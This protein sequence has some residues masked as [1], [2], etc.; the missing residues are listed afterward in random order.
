MADRIQL[1]DGTFF[2]LKTGETPEQA[3]AVA[4]Q[5]YPDAF[6]APVSAAPKQDTSGFKAAAA[7]GVE[8][9]G[10]EFEL[11]K[12]KLGLKSE[13]EAQR[14]FE[15]A[16]Q[17]AAQ[18]FTPTEKGWTEDPL[19]KFKETLGGSVPYMV[20]PAAAGLAALA[21][22]VT[23]PVAAGLGLL[24]A[25]AVSAGQFTG[26]NLAAQIDAGKTL[27]QASG[28]AALGAAIPQALLDTAAMALLPGVGKLFGSV[29][30]K[31]TTEQAK[32]IAS[33]TLLKTAADYT[34]KTGAAMTR[35]GFTEAAQQA[36]ERVQAGLNIADPEARAEYVESFIGGAVLA[37]AGAPIGRA[38]ER[39]GAKRQAEEAIRKEQ[40]DAAA[41]A[42]AEEEAAKTTPEA[43]RA[44]EASY[45][46]AE[47]QL[48]ALNAQV[49]AAKPAKNAPADAK[50]AYEEL[51]K[52]RAEFVNGTFKPLKQEY[53]KR[54]GAIAQMYDQQMAAAE[55]AAA[56]TQQAAV[57]PIPNAEPQRDVQ[58]LM[59]EQITLRNQL[60]AL[61]GRLAQAAPEQFDA[62]NAQRQELQRRIDARATLIEEMGGTPLRAA[63][64]EQA[65][66]AKMQAIDTRLEKLNAAYATA[67]ENRDYDK[68]ADAKDQLLI[69][70]QER[71]A[72]TAKTA[73][74]MQALQTQQ[75]AAQQRGQ[76][77]DMFPEAPAAPTTT[78]DDQIKQQ[79]LEEEKDRAL[80]GPEAKRASAEQAFSEA[81]I[82]PRGQLEPITPMPELKV[83]EAVQDKQVEAFEA[84]SDTVRAAEAAL[85]EA[86]KTKDTPTL[87]AAID[88][89]NEA[90]NAQ[91]RA[92]KTIGQRPV[93]PSEPFMLDI[94]S[95]ANIINTAIN[96]N[97]TKLIS[98][99]ARHADTTALRE[100]LDANKTERERLINVLEGRLDLG[101]TGKAK[102]TGE[103][104]RSVKR[105]RADLF[106]KQYD[107]K[108]RESFKNGTNTEVIKKPRTELVQEF[109]RDK[110]GN[111]V[112]GDDGK[113]V[114]VK[115]Y[116]RPVLDK[117]GQPV[118]D[119]VRLQDIYD[120]GGPAAVEYEN[121]MQA[122]EE[123]SK[124]VTTKQG[125]AKESLYEQMVR[126]YAELEEL[127]ARLESGIA[128]PTMREK[129]A[130]AQAAL[131][132]GEAP[133]SRQ[134]DAGERY[135][136]QR[137]ITAKQNK[138]NMLAGKIIPI[139]DQILALHN[140]LY[141][142][143]PLEKPSKVAKKKATAARKEARTQATAIQKG[144]A[145]T[146]KSRGAATASRINAGDVRKEAETSQKM[147]DL[148]QELGMREPAYEKYSKEL[149]RRLEALKK[150]HGA[151]DPAVN[152]FRSTVGDLRKDKAVE[153]GKTTPEY[154]AV[155]KEQIEYFKQTL[156]NVNYVV[157]AQR[158]PSQRTPQVTRK[159]SAA[160]KRLV[161]SSPESK[162]ESAREQEAYRKYRGSL[163]SFAE[164]I[165][166]EKEGREEDRF[167]RG[168]ETESVALAPS[169]VAKLERGDLRGALTDVSKDS[170]V[171]GFS[172]AVAERL[173]DFLDATDVRV[174]ADLRDPEGKKALGAATSKLI[175][176]SR[177][178]GLSVETLLHEGTH[179]AAE[180]IVQLAEDA[181]NKLTRE[182]KLAVNELKAL[183]ARVKTNPKITSKNAKSSLSEFV[184]E[185]MSNRNLQKQL[186][187]QKWRMSDM[188]QG[189]K[190]V[191]MRMLGLDK[192]ETMFGASVVAV[193]QLFV[194]SSVRN[195]G[196]KAEV[197]VTRNLS[198]KDI[199]ALHDG[200]NSMKQFAD[201][202]G[203]LIKQK[204]RTP[205]DVER[206]AM[207]A[208]Q[209]MGKDLD[210]TLS[211]PTADT[212]DYKAMATMSDGKLYDENNPLHY[213]EATPATFA[214]LQ[215]MEDPWL[216]KREA[217]TVAQQRKD[218]FT[219]LAQFFSDNYTNYTLAETAL[220]LKAASKYAVLS[221]KDGKLRLAELAPNNRH[222]VAVVGKE[223]ADAVIEQLRAGKNLKQAFLDGLQKNAD[224][225]AKNN[226]R[227]NGWK[228]FDQVAPSKTDDLVSRYTDEEV[229]NAL[230]ETGYDGGEFADDTE[231]V[232]QLIQD[233]L[234]EDRRKPSSGNLEA[235]AIELNAGCAGTPWC[236]GASV[237][238]A[239]SQIAE[240]DFYVYY[241]NGRPEVA[242]RM[243]GTGK[244]G[245]VR[246]N[247]PNQALDPEQQKIA[248]NFLRANKFER[249]DE[250]LSEFERRE[251]LVK[252]AK[253]EAKL[254][255]TDLLGEKSPLDSDGEVDA[256]EVSR[257]LKFRT[258]DGYG[259]RPK[260]VDS[261]VDFFGKQ[262]LDAATRAYENNE[263]VFSNIRV[264]ETT[265]RKG[266]AV[267]FAG[268]EYTATTDSL[269]AVKEITLSVYSYSR[270]PAEAVTFPNLKD[271][272]DLDIFSG[273]LV[274]PSLKTV[275]EV[276]FFRSESNGARAKIVLP[277]N[278]TVKE[279]HG[280]GDSAG[281]IEGPTTIELV[282]LAQKTGSLTLELPDTKYVA[283]AADTRGIS[284]GYARSAVEAVNDALEA[285][286]IDYTNRGQ[287]MRGE[288][289]PAQ[290]ATF[291][292]IAKPAVSKF[293]KAL[294]KEFGVETVEQT[295]SGTD[296]AEVDY[297]TA[298]REVIPDVLAANNYSREA[299]DKMAKVIKAATGADVT[300]PEGQL[301]APK[302]VGNP[303]YDQTFT[304]APEERR[305]APKDVGV[306]GDEKKGFSF[307]RKK[308]QAD[309]VVGRELGVV[310][311]LLGNILGLAGRVQFIDQYA[312]LEASIRKGLDAGVISDLEATN[313]NYLLRFGQQ[314][315]Q[316][317]GQFMTNGPVRAEI[318]KKAG[319]VET[320]YRS[321]KGTNMIDVAN[322]L[323]KAKLGDDIEQENMFTVY[324][325]GKRANDPSVG[326]DKLNFK[327][328]AKA[329]AEY[330]TV[331]SRL[332][333]SPEA[334]KAFEEAAKL[335]QEYNAGL[336]D[337]L[338]QTGALSAKKAAELKSISY[339]PFYRINGNGE[340]QLMIDKEHPVRIASIKDQ[341]QLKELI[342]GNTAILPIFTS[343]AQN[344]F[345]L[346][347][348]GLRNQAVK[349]TAFMLRKLGI[350]DRI[351][352]GMGPA[353]QNVVRFFKNGEP[354]H[355]VID[356]DAF[357]IPAELIV[358]GME[359]IKT[360]LPAV[361]K[362]LALPADILRSFV[363][364]NPAYA[365]RQM[366]RDPLNAWM[367]TGTDAVPVLSSMK[368]LAKM[369][370]GR[371]DA[372]RKLMETGAISS[373]VYSG[374]ERDMAM[375]MRDISAGKPFWAKA[376][377]KL[378]TFA[379]QGDASTRAV[380]YKDSL[381]KGMSEQEALLRTLESMN[382]SRR[383]VSPSMH[384]LS[385]MI[386]F[387]NAQIQGLDVIYR[388]FKGDMPYSK[389]LE[390]RA[391]MARRGVLI[392][393]GT[394]AYAAMMEDDEA[395]QR[396]KPEERY[397]SWFV[398]VPGF[399]EP[400]RVPIPFEM[401]FLFKA[402]PEAVWN[403]A[404][405]D[406]KA[407]K[408]LSG[409]GKLA[410]QTV[411]LSMPQAIKPLTEAVLGKSFYSGDI[412]SLREKD[413]DATQR[414]REN[415]TEVAKTIG[416]VTGKVGLSPITIDHLIRGYTAGLGIALVQLANPLLASDAKAAVE[417]PTT[418]DSKLPIIGNLFQPV[419]GRGTLDEA[420]ARM[421]EIRQAKGTYNKMVEE[422]RRAEAQ[423][424]A[425]AYAN[426]L[427]A[428]S[429]S[430]SVQKRLGDLAAV[431]RQ[432]RSS[433]TM[434]TA[435]KDAKLAQIDKMKTALAKQFL[436]A[437]D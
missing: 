46:T 354:H 83:E 295:L 84:A 419:E 380:V 224:D 391:K 71:E 10:G 349:E 232:E 178:G 101:G 85:A 20:A 67:L 322:A 321:A 213:V 407:D 41:K 294:E 3:L 91:T 215:A 262:Y 12:G 186:A 367:T 257:L 75:M 212:L 387:F 297:K 346:T 410:M 28:A 313:A 122:V 131:G 190:S 431:E 107:A 238:T 29:G 121:V 420:Y 23:A 270:K 263:F 219:S 281:V 221:G 401:G 355:V 16:Q 242:V 36:L 328:P 358:R 134:M 300:Y 13:A 193:E 405:Q 136:L 290:T 175:E 104:L 249:V 260:P 166:S 268:K 217:D 333:G 196:G 259:I 69:A 332:N 76:T 159:Q 251:A 230:G 168:V 278:A 183:Y 237:G 315:S 124:K 389:Q 258:I 49:G 291:E 363:V 100:A 255:V 86:V 382:F 369:V 95:P 160:P 408:A 74:Q 301:I 277:P 145:K 348:M 116:E 21:A 114:V 139:R 398:Y 59:D 152:F 164:G 56:P 151:N 250:Y 353:G 9:L 98:D 26:S 73:Q 120:Q 307:L 52:A 181:P 96:N 316:F 361:M 298:F 430:G 44:L 386:P 54:K 231:L 428:I 275:S 81:Q 27:E 403:V 141:V 265:A 342:G 99:L 424:Y 123:L 182:Q 233:G 22:P 138:F 188:W 88:K 72:L 282:T 113:P 220:V 37:G 331:L 338:V 169:T 119:V 204:D 296:I 184:A 279:V 274:L 397:S 14:E 422:G 379:M 347:G 198:A 214:A 345:M 172:R 394:L 320:V 78:V 70:K 103:P 319:G 225:N 143:T 93:A 390:I 77:L 324:L 208:I 24:G 167:L 15:A 370:A 436:A 203:P 429:I 1:P 350:A 254:S 201:Q 199:A 80:Y 402:L 180:R 329:K 416:A 293:F 302:R 158:A 243:D 409:I 51:K 392:A 161:T 359:G 406:E 226:E 341:P 425:Q 435:E 247:N 371:S 283:T 218:D 357:G 48:A 266:I 106:S 423:A 234:L 395:Y 50:Q 299:F 317:A 337:F 351:G 413:V 378:D 223:D 130:T 209:D 388:A 216:R 108:Q 195:L 240:G 118:I 276:T 288:G 433:P 66:A 135:Q 38:F 210:K 292:A 364:R 411:P 284:S 437:T 352:Q 309:S 105:E 192:V 339:V 57:A 280:Y 417:K 31:L 115:Q 381:A 79:T 393:A 427:A 189:V 11:L 129:V 373:N 334:K 102:A 170:R 126:T 82:G 61:E 271:V 25:G 325:A 310:D 89:L 264:D 150:K 365:I 42:A 241:K 154:K 228:K 155:L 205:E 400:V 340:V 236:T 62:L 335:Y 30:S 47:Q 330:D 421:T 34:A 286:G 153:I 90:A 194:P 165:A 65:T 414:Y 4:R 273:E 174:V 97:D 144:K 432:I 8:R 368:E 94:F 377:A 162:T 207:Q 426:K 360:T 177:D 399:D 415:T 356:N 45:K 64:F 412:E 289:T 385:V 68:A 133:A 147:R 323:N 246:G 156:A 272:Q 326:W 222:N 191:I 109:Q 92:Q 303:P 308:P 418:K 7:A 87:Y 58:R 304:E 375:F 267:K 157:G 285:K 63:E 396:A 142:M 211:V 404:M 176:I 383:G 244:I 343:A 269:K 32:A 127:Q 376:V 179:A 171:D 132:K 229:N 35:E 40:A 197:K 33:Q 55:M 261:V 314:R 202:F 366:I 117:K 252:L 372:E 239:R 312:A 206:I 318:T 39:S 60:D 5:M 235:A 6:A 187:Q 253:G 43:L 173:L 163:R 384:A 306:Q 327:D 185:V 140:S 287:I 200:T 19:L 248:A 2:P 434:T 227:K 245:E 362:L 110:Q 53:D 128:A 111:V 112:L 311:T 305:F 125:N 149:T 344:T 374:D 256:F 18:R 148:A 146:P 336:L 17:R 137:Q